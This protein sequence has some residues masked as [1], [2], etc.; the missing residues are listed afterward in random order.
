[1]KHYILFAI[2]LTILNFSC[3]GSKKTG[4]NDEDYKA[5]AEK[6]FTKDFLTQLSPN[7]D[8]VVCYRDANE[9]IT[10]SYK[11][12]GYFIYDIKNKK[13]I[14]EENLL[15][16]GSYSWKNERVLN[17]IPNKEYNA[18]TTGRPAGYDFD[19]VEKKVL[20]TGDGKE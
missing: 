6:K 13:I 1:M 12:N 4:G 7:G 2:F 3:A 20:K 16:G 15:R 5:I 9:A 11:E 18:N 19:V 10:G 14:R 8:F 17:I